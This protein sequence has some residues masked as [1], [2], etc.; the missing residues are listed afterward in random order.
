MT[1]E[2]HRLGRLTLTTSIADM[3]MA[4]TLRPR[5]EALAAKR[6]P[7]VMAR[8]FDR[9]V[10]AD[11]HLSLARLDIDLGRI[12]PDTIDD[13]LPDALEA[14]LTEALTEAIHRARHT[15]DDDA[16]LIDPARKA[17]ERF[18]A[19][20][21][22]GL[23]PRAAP[24]T[25]F[26]AAQ[27][28]AEL[29]MT[30]PDA[31]I[32]ML[33]AQSGNRYRL[34]R[35][36]LQ[37]GA[38]GLRTLLDLL[39]PADAALIM[40]IIADTLRLHR[41]PPVASEIPIA[42]PAL[43]RL[44]W[45]ATLEFLLRDAG[46]QF[47][48]RRF[49]EHLLRRE[50]G[51]V[52][53]SFDRL[54]ALLG[55]AL[56]AAQTRTAL[57]SSLPVI[58]A[59]LLDE[60]DMA[61]VDRPAPP[62]A[63]TLEDAL[64]AARGGDLAALIAI[65]RRDAGDKARLTAIVE[66]MDD[67]LFAAL[68]KALEPE[69]A[70]AILA[71]LHDVETAHRVDRGAYPATAKTE[72]AIQTLL[73]R[74]TLVYLVDDRGSQ[75]NRRQF[76]GAL[77][78]RA[79]GE[80]DIGYDVLVDRLAAASLRQQARFGQRSSLPAMLADLAANQAPPDPR[81]PAARIAAAISEAGR[82]DTTALLALLRETADDPDALVAIV[83]AI[84]PGSFKNLIASLRPGEAAVLTGRIDALAA[85]HRA[86]RAPLITAADPVFTT[87]LRSA[88]LRLMLRSKTQSIAPRAWIDAV[89]RE[90]APMTGTTL[91]ALHEWLVL[92]L[93]KD[94]LGDAFLAEVALLLPPSGAINRAARIQAA[95]QADDA[96][97]LALLRVEAG[98]L[99]SL[100]GLAGRIDMPRRSRLLA[101]TSGGAATAIADDLALFENL[102]RAGALPSIV[103]D[104]F[105][106][107]LWAAA[108]AYLIGHGAARFDRTGFRRWIAAAIARQSGIGRPRLVAA[109]AAHRRA[110]P[111]DQAAAVT[112]LLGAL[113]DSAD[114]AAPDDTRR[115]V[116]QFLMTGQPPRAGRMLPDIA[117]GDG[118]WLAATIRRLAR[119]RPGSR[120]ALLRHLLD[121]LLPAELIDCLLPGQP[122]TGW[123]LA[124]GR[125]TIDDW[126]KPFEAVLRGELP[127]T[128]RRGPRPGSAFDRIDAI[129]HWLDHGAWPWW[130][131]PR[132][133]DAMLA[134][135]PALDL[136]ELI[137]LFD[138][139]APDRRFDRF[140]RAVLAL[141]DAQRRALFDRLIPRAT[142]MSAPL[143]ALLADGSTE[144]Q[145]VRSIRVALAVLAGE[146][147][148]LRAIGQPVP[149]VPAVPPPP[150]PP[151]P[152]NGR[153]AG[154][155]T[156]LLLAWLDGRWPGG[157]S[158][159]AAQVDSLRRH[160]A[161]LADRGDPQLG[162]HLR[163]QRGDRQARRRWVAMLPDAALAR[164]VMLLAPGEGLAYL[165]AARLL[166]AAARRLATA[167]QSAPS[168]ADYWTALLDLAA[169]PG[170]VA[171][172][173]A[174]A[175]LDKALFRASANA[176][177]RQLQA[178][179]LAEQA[180][181]GSIAA[182]LRRITTPRPSRPP[183]ATQRS[184]PPLA[185]KATVTA[186]TDD[187]P[188]EP[189]GAVYIDNAG[190]VL[191][192]PYLPTLFKRLKL[193]S[194]NE[195]GK[196]AVTGEEAP[197]RAVHLLQYLVDGRL[198]APEP[199]LPLNKLLCG[200]PIAHPVARDIMIEAEE[201][202][203]LDGLLTAAISSWPIIKNSSIAALRETFLQREGRLLRTDSGWQLTVQ[204][205]ALDVLV[206]QIPW[207]F[208]MIYHRW[209]AE[210]VHVTW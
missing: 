60:R 126:I 174:I 61:P 163:K 150:T 79:A 53:L 22:T 180:G 16:R 159:D 71:I 64:A 177:P 1:V 190:L 136:A 110:L 46:S 95:A 111:D 171:L 85:L 38:A 99:T 20:L 167:G 146:A 201:R 35:L 182:A 142:A 105:E 91:G 83:A 77:L 98:D 15:P 80:L 115:A 151:A 194:E 30:Q 33:R 148:D 164:L 59:E 181:H 96:A 25:R 87:M 34:E 41:D 122:T 154:V 175:R 140:R 118:A 165:T 107:L 166:V 199:A 43:E 200:L 5:L 197:S 133:S 89:L 205:K 101:L 121:W 32:A 141:N 58:L 128:S 195:G 81:S 120:R 51:R 203:L 103:Q 178:L 70:D 9:L 170:A 173:V 69:A 52:G 24:G 54:L 49:L 210:P 21:A 45:V 97:L 183:V 145:V 193:L 129:A 66:A 112:A 72:P 135:L 4:L 134:A 93:N 184:D 73:R 18:E 44:L 7:E 88:L 155:D 114:T 47:N 37:L 188:P 185:D 78:R 130:V 117:V 186:N 127:V 2:P 132:D 162:D 40:A 8:V 19:F 156:A 100:I 179:Q 161:R 90:L 153:S 10:P 113:G 208:S 75:F 143:A 192:S 6:L 68:I 149:N 106:R 27:V 56:Q 169:E 42:E 76:L 39:A 116:L 119:E 26:D 102:H 55:Q 157:G 31:L 189:T 57:R 176:A 206:D 11:M 50:V 12:A 14:A 187:P 124:S 74:I 172:P 202:E 13:D 36:V 62:V 139:A 3:D 138:G 144:Q 123:P 48:R 147:V 125:E 131:R 137:W 209:M 104:D 82:G 17:L 152:P 160:F 168:L 109:M 28:L 29:A 158:P 67:P 86:A 198:D 92:A 63:L 191:L 207:T 84:S 204:R 94:D 196:A 108:M 23:A 65:V